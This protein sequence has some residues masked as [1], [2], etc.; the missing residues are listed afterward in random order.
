[1]HSF[2]RKREPI[3]E[4]C[5]AA[6]LEMDLEV[7]LQSIVEEWSEQVLSFQLNEA[8]NI[9]LLD[10]AFAEHL[11]GEHCEACGLYLPCTS[12]QDHVGHESAL[13]PESEPE[14]ELITFRL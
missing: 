7:Q 1:M 3:E 12:S 9:Q 4:I 14:P 8:R 5:R 11:I 6:K 2:D 13:A 10:V